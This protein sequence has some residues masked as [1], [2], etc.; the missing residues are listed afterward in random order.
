MVQLF[1]P[2]VEEEAAKQK[3]Q[4][5]LAPERRPYRQPEQSLPG[6]ER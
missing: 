6:A 5:R 3:P 1:G 2:F 4:L